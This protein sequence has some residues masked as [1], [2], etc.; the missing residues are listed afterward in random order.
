MSIGIGSGRG[1]VRR[2]AGRPPGSKDKRR[3]AAQAEASGQKL[4]LDI[5]LEIIN[6]PSV[7]EARRDKFVIA[8]APYLHPRL[9]SIAMAKAPFEMTKEEVEQTLRR[10]AEHELRHGGMSPGGM[11]SVRGVSGRNQMG[12]RKP[13]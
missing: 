3:R 2:G 10:Q 7:S 11:A 6:D 13:R 1:G 4:P 12:E 8:A 5:M 9:S